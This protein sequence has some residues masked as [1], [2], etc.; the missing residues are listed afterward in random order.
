MEIAKISQRELASRL[1]IS[2][3]MVS[4]VIN[5]TA[6]L[7]SEEIVRWAQATRADQAKI[8]ELL[9]LHE[10]ASRLGTEPIPPGSTV[11]SFSY[12]L[13]QPGDG[14]PYL[15]VIVD[16]SELLVANP[17]PALVAAHRRVLAQITAEAMIND[18]G[19]TDPDHSQPY[20]GPN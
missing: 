10:H 2:Q 5:G 18:P 19:T 11:W 7:S 6:T 4:R 20:P 9:Q 3:T 13:I 8:E 1:N 12:T 17:D 16:Q 15:G 14:P